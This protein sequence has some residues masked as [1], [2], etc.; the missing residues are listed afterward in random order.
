MLQCSTLYTPLEATMHMWPTDKKYGFCSPHC[1]HTLTLTSAAMGSVP[2]G[3]VVN[4][5][6]NTVV[7]IISSL[8]ANSIGIVRSGLQNQYIDC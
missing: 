1:A 6:I 3:T 5:E 8:G 7:R 2:E 4:N